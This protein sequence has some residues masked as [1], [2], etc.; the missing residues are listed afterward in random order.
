MKKILF[1]ILACALGLISASCSQSRLEIP[2]KGVIPMESFYKTDEDAVSAITSVYHGFATNVASFKRGNIYN[3]W[4]F[5]FNLPGDDVYAACKEYGNNDFQA[6]INEF[7]FDSSNE[8]ISNCYALLYL[9]NYYCNLVTDN[10]GGDKADTPT[11]KRCVAEARV[12]RAWIHMTLAIGWGTPPLVDHVLLGSDKPGNYQGTRE[13]LLRWCAKECEEAAPDLYE[14]ESTAEDGSYVMFDY[15]A[16]TVDESSYNSLMS[17]YTQDIIEAYRQAIK[18]AAPDTVFASNEESIA[19][20]EELAKDLNVTVDLY[21]YYAQYYTYTLYDSATYVPFN[22]DV[23]E[24]DETGYNYAYGDFEESTAVL[25]VNDTDRNG[26]PMM[27]MFI[28]YSAVDQ[29]ITITSAS[30]VDDD[31][32]EET[33]TPTDATNAW[34]L[35]SSIALVVAMVAAI[36]VLLIKDLAKKLK[37]RPKVAKNTYN[38]TKNKR[39]VRTYVKEHGET[40]PAE[41]EQPAESAGE[42]VES[43]QPAENAD[44]PVENEQPAESV[45]EPV[46][47]EQPAENA[48]EPAEVNKEDGEKSDN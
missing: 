18:A 36:A 9:A 46:E 23:A 40:K 19:Y 7:R 33:T 3:S 28:D 39:Y 1:P 48:D 45:G 14:R 31:E 30:D 24:E 34:L 27:N 5:A 6:E 26:A 22:E 25:K 43:E 37:R 11:K 47:S 35:A 38:Y 21:D 13:D 32:E 2:Q 41:S 44:A 10:F 16:V 29:N 4:M 17:E 42:P 15:S 12:I 20:Y 8:I